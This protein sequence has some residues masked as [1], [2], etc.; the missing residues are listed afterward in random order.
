[1]DMRREKGKRNWSDLPLDIVERII[2]DLDWV[3]GISI[4]NV[5]KGWAAVSLSS[6]DMPTLDKFPWAMNFRWR[7][8]DNRH[9]QIDGECSLIYPPLNHQIDGECSLIYP[10]LNKQFCAEKGIKGKEF[11]FFLGATPQASSYEKISIHIC[12]PGDI[13]WKTFE[14]KGFDNRFIPTIHDAVYANGIFFCVF[15]GGQL[16]AFNLQLEDW[17]MLTLEGLGLP[18][19]DFRYPKLI[20]SSNGDLRLIGTDKSEG[21]SSEPIIVYGENENHEEALKL[22]KFDLCEKRWVKETSLNGRVLFIGSKCFSCPAEGDISELANNVFSC[23]LR[24]PLI[25]CYG[26]KSDS[27]QYK[28]WAD[29]VWQSRIWIEMPSK[30]IWGANDLINAVR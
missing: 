21:F 29:T 19:F 17:T 5:C 10:P 3:D 24:H 30:G 26:A 25:R 12:S 7:P 11:K 8:I 9:H 14:F 4:R 1:M 22:F 15:F 6:P 2:G 23:C 13:A 16:G 27:V 28:N 18:V 20:A